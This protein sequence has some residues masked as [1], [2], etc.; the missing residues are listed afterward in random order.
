MGD[1][2]LYIDTFS[3][4]PPLRSKRLSCLP[5]A[6]RTKDASELLYARQKVVVTTKAFGLQA[7]DLV[8]ID[9]KDVEGLRRQAREGALMGFTGKAPHPPPPTP[10]PPL[11]SACLC[12]LEAS[13]F[14]PSPRS[15]LFRPYLLFTLPCGTI[16]DFPQLPVTGSIQAMA[17]LSSG[18]SHILGKRGKLLSF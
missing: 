13:D 17:A 10:V 15:P 16:A 2:T 7:I 6:T 18:F 5:G 1:F 12:C 8:Y 14:C 4:C 9:Y 11:T 3:F